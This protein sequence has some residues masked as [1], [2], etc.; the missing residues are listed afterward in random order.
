MMLLDLLISLE[1]YQVLTPLI[2]M[3]MINYVSIVNCFVH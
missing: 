3:M 1:K 2:M